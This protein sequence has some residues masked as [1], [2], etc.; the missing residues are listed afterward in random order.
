MLPRTLH[1]CLIEAAE[2]L[3]VVTLTGPR[4]SGKTT[5][6]RAAFPHLPYVSL[7]APDTR[8][9]ALLDPRGFLNALPDGA[10]LDEVQRA[11][12]LPSY[13]Q[14]I[15]DQDPRPGRFILTGS[16]NLLL[17]DRVSQTL[18]G[19]TRILNL[20]PFS[21]A[22]LD[23]REPWD[24]EAE[25]APTPS[26][27]TAVERSL[28]TT[29]H[30]GFY[31]RI[32]DRELDPVPWLA[33][34]R[35]TYV[36]RDV[37]QILNVHDLEVFA[38]FLGLCAGRNGQIL[39]VSSLGNDAGV[40][41]TTARRWLSI[42]EASFLIALLRPYHRNFGK[43]LI[44]SP[45]IYFLDSGLLCSLLGIRNADEL[46]VHASRGA[47]FE[48]FVL[49]EL[50]KAYA[51]RGRRPPVYFWRDS[52]GHEIDF[53]IE[54]GSRL[55]AIE[56]KSGETAPSSFF[57]GLAWWRRLTDDPEA[58]ALLLYGGD[59]DFEHRGVPARSWRTL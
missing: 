42:L 48:S 43:R 20:H 6:V 4:Q 16:Q 34:Y 11:P 55:L 28:H 56:A 1:R 2:T 25:S 29:L 40:D 27:A 32:H 9:R 17:L 49:A 14:G 45:K 30:T 13:I 23:R 58:P 39:N 47:V 7:E 24:P 36:E 10:V 19:R 50:I 35:A 53:L 21:L 8:E 18:A 46:R 15:V 51:H 59:E 33:D 26:G 41:H 57:D 31:P 37:R 22:E 3:P 5:L 38:R 12:D 54:Q 52:A 44:K